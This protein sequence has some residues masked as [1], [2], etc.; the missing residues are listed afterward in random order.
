MIPASTNGPLRGLL[1]RSEGTKKETH[2][3]P[4]YAL[5]KAIPPVLCHAMI[6]SSPLC[7]RSIQPL[8]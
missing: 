5:R 1:R 8:R 6:M 7:P 4:L 2:L 3:P